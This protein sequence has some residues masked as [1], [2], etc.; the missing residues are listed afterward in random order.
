MKRPAKLMVARRQRLERDRM[1]DLICK[2]ADAHCQAVEA[3]A[4]RWAADVAAGRV[5]VRGSSGL[6]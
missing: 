1:I 5:R 4:K 2:L 6:I 3:F